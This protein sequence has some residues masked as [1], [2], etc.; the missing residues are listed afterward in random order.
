M[1]QSCRS[2]RLPNFVTKVQAF[3]FKYLLD[4]CNRHQQTFFTFEQIQ[5][6]T[7]VASLLQTQQ[8]L[9]TLSRLHLK[10]HLNQ[11]LQ[12]HLKLSLRLMLMLQLMVM[13]QMMLMLQLMLHLRC[14]QGSTLMGREKQVSTCMFK[15]HL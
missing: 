5:G 12:L 9:S 11:N 10:L 13:L 3:F 8:Q 4:N 14:Y 15:L 1:E 6:S 2:A 7:L